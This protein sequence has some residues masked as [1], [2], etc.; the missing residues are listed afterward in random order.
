MHLR[1]LALL[2]CD[3]QPGRGA[4]CCPGGALPLLSAGRTALRT[5][6]LAGSELH[7]PCDSFLLHTPC[8]ASLDLSN[9]I[10]VRTTCHTHPHSGCLIWCCDLRASASA[11]TR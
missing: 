1:E 4:G 8:L 11:S 7:L 10:A 6:S 3:V 9:A 2:Q 5:L